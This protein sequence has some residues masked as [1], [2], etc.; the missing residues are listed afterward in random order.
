M[1]M[2]KD[3]IIIGGTQKRKDKRGK[4]GGGGESGIGVR[5]IETQRER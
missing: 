3:A 1:G 2:I 4:K 5:E